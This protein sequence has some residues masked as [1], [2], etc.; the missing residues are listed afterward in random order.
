M[1]TYEPRVVIL[2]AYRDLCADE[3]TDRELTE[4]ICC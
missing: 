4:E 2:K 1:K 3:H